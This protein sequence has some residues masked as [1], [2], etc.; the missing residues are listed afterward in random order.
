MLA[1]PMLLMMMPDDYGRYDD[2]DGHN[3]KEAAINYTYLRTFN[4]VLKII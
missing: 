1:M 4:V 3:K 2:D